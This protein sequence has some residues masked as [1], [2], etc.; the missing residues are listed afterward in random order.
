MEDFMRLKQFAVLSAVI[1]I[2]GIL[3]SSCGKKKDAGN[4]MKVCSLNDLTGATSTVGADYARGVKE[5]IAYVNDNG[6]INGKKIDL[7]LQ[8][9][10]YKADKAKQIY[11]KFKARGCIAVLGWGSADTE[12]LT[13]TVARDK[14]PYVSASYSAKLNDPQEAPYNF[15]IAPDYSTQVR[16]LLT[17]WYNKNWKAKGK[18]GSPK[19]AFAYHFGHPFSSASIAEAKKHAKFLGYTVGPDQNVSL[20]AKEVQTQVAALKKFKPNVVVHTNTVRTVAITLVEAHA[21]KLKADH[22][23]KNWGFDEYLYDRAGKAA[24]GAY[25]VAPWAFYGMNVPLMDKVKEYAKKLH[26]NEKKR[27]IHTI[28]GWGSVL[29]LVKALQ[30]ADTAKDLSGEGILK[31][32]ETFKDV[33]FGLGIPP[34]TFTS[35]DHR[36]MSGVSVYQIKGGKFILFDTVDMAKEFPKKWATEWLGK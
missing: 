7:F 32:F 34:V 20:A 28:Q 29:A 31:A 35:K 12:A 25:G 10:G 8:D 22:L 21:Q 14:M 33:D 16:G 17:S 6:G 13:K 1:L 26:P 30:I 11:E 36:S 2:S 4:M 24:E 5:A 9:Y 19:V 18:K 23:I 27:T 3:V 15:F